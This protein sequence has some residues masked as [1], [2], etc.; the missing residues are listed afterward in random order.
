M[1]EIFR[2]KQSKHMVMRQLN[3]MIAGINYIYERYTKKN[4]GKEY[5]FARLWEDYYDDNPDE[6]M[7]VYNMIIAKK[8]IEEKI[9]SDNNLK[10]IRMAVKNYEN[11]QE[12]IK[13]YFSEKDNMEIYQMYNVLNK[14][15]HR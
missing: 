12:K 3:E 7:T 9:I 10:C 11:N 4:R 1:G 14:C 6:E 8:N 2:P 15:F 5:V 13:M